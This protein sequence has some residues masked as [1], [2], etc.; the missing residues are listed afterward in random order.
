M[1]LSVKNLRNLREWPAATGMDKEQFKALLPH[2][3][4]AYMKLYGVSIEQAQANL[5][6][7][8][9]FSTYKDFLIK[10]NT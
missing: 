7:K 10:L 6:K 3:K 8:F 4:S 2:F 9:V 1:A 5:N